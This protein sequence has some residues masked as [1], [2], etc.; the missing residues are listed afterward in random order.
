MI[1]LIWVIAGSIGF[2]AIKGGIFTIA[3]LGAVPG[4]GP[5]G[6][7][8]PGQQRVRAGDRHVDSRFGP[9]SIRSTR[10]Q[11]WVRLGILAAIGLSALSAIGSHSRGAVVAI[12]AMAIFLWF[13]SRESSSL[14][15]ADRDRRGLALVAFMPE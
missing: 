1:A 10:T 6:Q 12:V 11:P 14:G 9:T 13:K 2:Y 3:T 8:H 4:L 7:L 15:A 5:G